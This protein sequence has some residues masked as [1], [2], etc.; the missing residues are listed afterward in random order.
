[1]QA[2]FKHQGFYPEL[3]EKLPENLRTEL[4]F[5]KNFFAPYT[6]RVYMVGGSVRDLVRNEIFHTSYSITDLD[7]EVYG[8]AP[9][10]FDA[11]MQK[12]GAKGVGKSFF[13]YK[14][15][16]DIDISLPRIESKVGKGHRAFHVELAK[17]E[18]EA[19]RR[20]DFRMN[21]LMLNI[22]DGKLLDFWGG[23]EDIVHRRIAIIDSQKFKEDSLRVLRAMQFSARFGFRI[24]PKSAAIMCEIPLDDLSHERIF[25]EFEKMFLGA[26]LH[27]G[28][29]YLL[30]LG[31]AKKIFGIA[32]SRKIYL[33]T[34]L[35]MQRGRK[36]FQPKLYKFYFLYIFAK[37]LHKRFD[38]FLERL[39]TPRVYFQAFRK[40]KS[41]P[42]R[43]SDRFLAALAMRFGLKEY[44]GNYKIDV[45]ERAKKL[46]LWEKPFMPVTPKELLAEGF[47]GEALGKELRK[48]TLQIIRQRF[49]A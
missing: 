4:E 28:L 3:L 13:V 18:K 19:S 39:H 45:Q 11:L 23:V 34:A 1:M 7:L 8:I 17:D 46:G 21:A 6:K 24:E 5:L 31:I 16:T 43:R 10:E 20:R 41:L 49:A 9:E 42:K 36:H 15:K 48:R 2:R 47:A 38:Y 26:Y 44:L 32:V 12:L 22:F 35:E 29:Y 37:N 33:R 27:Y 30:A 25:W 14:Y 40:Q